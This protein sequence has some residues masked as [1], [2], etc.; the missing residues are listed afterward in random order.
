MASMGQ[1]RELWDGEYQ[2]GLPIIFNFFNNQYGMGVR[3]QARPWALISWLGSGPALI[4]AMHAE[5]IDGYNP[6]AVI[7]AMRN[8]RQLLEEKRG[9]V[10]LDTVTYRFA[11]HSPSD[12][13]SYRTKRN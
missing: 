4:R 3:P 2:G 5:R 12:S 1:F 9:P 11:G 6:L 13:S 7:D 8:K 10:L